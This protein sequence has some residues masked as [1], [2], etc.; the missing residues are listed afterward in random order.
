VPYTHR[1]F[2]EQKLP[3]IVRSR[4]DISASV[5]SAVIG[6]S[7]AEQDLEVPEHLQELF[8]ET[9]E[10]SKL[11]PA[12]QQYLPDILRRNSLAFATG[13]MDIGF[14]DAIQHDIETGDAKPI[15]QA[16]LRPPLAA[17]D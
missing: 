12:N 14:C 2:D 10:R 5:L 15:K 13:S 6:V 7:V 1:E 4:S 17:R 9:V 3:N 16:L 11:S 8:D